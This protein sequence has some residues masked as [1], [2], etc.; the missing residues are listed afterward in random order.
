MTD[1]LLPD[2]SVRRD[3][4]DELD[5]TD[6]LEHDRLKAITEARQDVAEVRLRG[7]VRAARV[8]TRV[9][10]QG[11]R[12]LYHEALKNYLQELRP[13][14]HVAG[15]ASELWFG[16]DGDDPPI[17]GHE[18]LPDGRDLLIR[19]LRDLLT[20]DATTQVTT[21]ETVDY[22]QGPPQTLE[23]TQNHALTRET[24]DNGYGW[25]NDFAR[26]LGLD[27]DIGGGGDIDADAI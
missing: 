20:Q 25:A 12:I 22:P 13:Y 27:I 7:R 10:Q 23:K 14:R 9:N 17:I 5:V 26:R 6:K 8:E 15:T 2:F 11:A 3:E 16:F 24:L 1:P 4:P 21:E 18:V 19:C